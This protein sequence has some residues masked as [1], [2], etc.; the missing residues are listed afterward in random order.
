M[1]TSLRQLLHAAIRESLQNCCSWSISPGVQQAVRPEA[2]PE[3]WHVAST[4]ILIKQFHALLSSQSV[5]AIARKK[6]FFIS[7]LINFC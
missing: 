2:K 7:F 6:I 1:R 5:L 4:L 3:T